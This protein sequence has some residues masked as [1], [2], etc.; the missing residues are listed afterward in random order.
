MDMLEFAQN[1]VKAAN[2]GQVTLLPISQRDK[3]LGCI[4]RFRLGSR[5]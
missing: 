2:A 5:I 1:A 4:I 3:A